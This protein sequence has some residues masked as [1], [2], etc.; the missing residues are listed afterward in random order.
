MKDKIQKIENSLVEIKDALKTLNL[1]I[2][3]I[4]KE[5]QELSDSNEELMQKNTL[6]P[7]KNIKKTPLIRRVEEQEESE[8][9]APSYT[10]QVVGLGTTK[11]DF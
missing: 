9:V 5:I 7:Q 10:I 4:E 11:V 8:S 6:S 3:K 2:Q 1:Y